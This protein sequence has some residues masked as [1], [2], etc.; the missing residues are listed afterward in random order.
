MVRVFNERVEDFARSCVTALHERLQM[1]KE[2]AAVIAAA[3]RA[4]SRHMRVSM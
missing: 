4:M 3:T 1:R 2:R